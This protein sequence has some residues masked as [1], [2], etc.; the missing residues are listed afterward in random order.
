[1]GLIELAGT[2]AFKSKVCKP[3]MIQS[4]ASMLE[5]SEMARSTSVVDEFR[6]GLYMMAEYIAKHNKLLLT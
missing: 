6:R 3:S 1:M 4:L 5:K 2:S